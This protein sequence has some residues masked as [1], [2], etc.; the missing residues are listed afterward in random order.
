MLVHEPTPAEQ[1]MRA[2]DVSLLFA[3]VYK[4]GGVIRVT[5][6]ELRDLPPGLWLTIRPD[7]ET[8]DTVIVV[9]PR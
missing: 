1:L 7:V 8:G 3:I 2:A 9:Q 4:A 5:A 6:Q